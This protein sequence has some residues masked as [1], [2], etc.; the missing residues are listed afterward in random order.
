MRP[1]VINGCFFCFQNALKLTYRHPQ[2][3]KFFVILPDPIKGEDGVWEGRSERDRW[4]G[5][6]IMEGRKQ[7]KGGVKEEGQGFWKAGE[8]GFLAS[9]KKNPVYRPAEPPQFLLKRASH[10]C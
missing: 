7:G 5:M 8:G 9:S 6:Q 10:F 1:D 3:L 2:L 4:E